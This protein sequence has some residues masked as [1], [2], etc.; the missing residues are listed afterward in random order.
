MAK[1]GEFL[2]R[3]YYPQHDTLRKNLSLKMMRVASGAPQEELEPVLGIS[4]VTQ[5]FDALRYAE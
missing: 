1:Y 3:C 5:M 2:Q 4:T